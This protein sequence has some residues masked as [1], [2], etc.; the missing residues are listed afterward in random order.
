MDILAC[1]EASKGHSAAAATSA[2]LDSERT[3]EE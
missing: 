1:N 3:G 2:H